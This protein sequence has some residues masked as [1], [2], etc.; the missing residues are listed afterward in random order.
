M[1][2]LAEQIMAPYVAHQALAQQPAQLSP[3]QRTGMGMLVNVRLDLPRQLGGEEYERFE[4]WV[5][6][7]FVGRVRGVILHDLLHPPAPPQQGLVVGVIRDSPSGAPG[8]VQVYAAAE[9]PEAAS[10][11]LSVRMTQSGVMTAGGVPIQPMMAQPVPVAQTLGTITEDERE[12]EEQH[13]SQPVPSTWVGPRGNF[14][15][16]EQVEDAEDGIE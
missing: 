11:L 12:S 4:E 5:R 9:I 3:Q 2:Q 7:D 14:I 10:G 8:E 1:R 13:H 16:V 15:E 6:N